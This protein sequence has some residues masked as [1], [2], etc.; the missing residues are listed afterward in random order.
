MY[1]IAFTGAVTLVFSLIVCLALCLRWARGR[2]FGA[3][4]EGEDDSLTC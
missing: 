2:E 4:A 1:G 3:G